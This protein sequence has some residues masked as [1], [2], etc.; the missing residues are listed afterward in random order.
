MK[1]RPTDSAARQRGSLDNRIIVLRLL[2]HLAMGGVQ[3]SVATQLAHHDKERFRFL[4]LTLKRR[5]AWPGCLEIPEFAS[6]R[7]IPI[8]HS[9]DNAGIAALARLLRREGVDILH[10]HSYFPNTVGRQAALLAGVPVTIAHYHSTY[11]HR[12]DLAMAAWERVLFPFTS[13]ALMVSSRAQSAWAGLTGLS[14]ERTEIVSNL[15]DLSEM[16]AAAALPSPALDQTL[17]QCQPDWPLICSVGRLVPLKRT[18]D[19]I[20]AMA[21]LKTRGR[22]ARLVIAGEGPQRPILEQQIR[23]LGLADRVRLLG[24]IDDVGPLLA[25]AA[26][27]TLASDVEGFSRCSLEAMACAA[28]IITTPIGGVDE[29][30]PKGEFLR[31]IPHRDP[32]AL[33]DALCDLW[34]HPEETARRIERASEAVGRFDCGPWVRRLESIY[35]HEIKEAWLAKN[36]PWGYGGA[37][38]GGRLLAERLRW[39]LLRRLRPSSWEMPS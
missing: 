4:A 15:I 17:A 37:L 29:I 14:T 6:S 21:I 32:T 20:E 35:E 33:A 36:R 34:D 31:L 5:E 24:C 11:G 22:P 10:C 7:L 19:I 3:K 23:R 1:E 2:D 13:R 9:R 26:A 8:R 16:R 27:M 28:P 38:A 39:R 30:D 18:G 25:R 12:R